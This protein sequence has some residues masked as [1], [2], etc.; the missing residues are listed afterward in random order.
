[1]I[2]EFDPTTV[3]WKIGPLAGWTYDK[4]VSKWFQGSFRNVHRLT[5]PCPTCTEIIPLDVTVKALRGDAKNHGLS[6][7]RCKACRAALKHAPAEYAERRA[8]GAGVA[9]IV[10]VN[11]T[12]D[13]EAMEALRMANNVM[14]EELEGL[15]AKHKTLF[16]ECQALKARLSVFELQGAMTE[17]SGIPPKWQA[18]NDGHVVFSLKNKMPWESN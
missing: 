1:M 11:A 9:P 7:R 16:A 3:D 5:R 18:E 6:L 10:Q 17:V 13:S 12:V 2:F 14:K 4:P 8:M 15:Y